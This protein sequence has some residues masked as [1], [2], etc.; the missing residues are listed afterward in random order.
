MILTLTNL[1][2]T[3]VKVVKV[4]I[5]LVQFKRKGRSPLWIP[6]TDMKHSSD[7]K[8]KVIDINYNECMET[9]E[10]KAYDN[11][12]SLNALHAPVVFVALSLI[13]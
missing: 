5:Q 3:F 13:T 12:F 2:L 10:R 4:K 6:K 1:T 11:F 9:K 7:S 8:V